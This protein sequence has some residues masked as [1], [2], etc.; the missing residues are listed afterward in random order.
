MTDPDALTV[1]T[2]AIGPFRQRWQESGD[3]PRVLLLHGIYAGASSYEWRRLAPLLVDAGR[4]VRTPDLLGFGDSDHP[5]LEFSPD[6]V[7]EAVRTLL[8]D[9]APATVVAS[10]LTGAYA[11]RAV[12]DG[13]PCERLVLITPTGLGGA[14]AQPSGVL[15]RLAYDV[16]RHTPMGD[17]LVRGLS[18]RPSIRWFLDHQTYTTRTA[19]DDEVEQSR[20]M[21]RRR[22][23][24]HS[25]LAFVFNRLALPVDPAHVRQ[26]APTVIWADGQ[27]FTDPADATRWADAG[28]V[29]EHRR[30][31]LPQVEEPESLLDV[32]AP[33]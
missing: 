25:Q 24:K 27:G 21:A 8:A 33:G 12:A 10:S 22:N 31:G 18:S 17:A 4:Q 29:V 30:C 26:V 14:Q 20:R 9:A 2:T 3:G 13:A 19:D 1:G 28:A 5:D 6:V 32:L 16:G 11:L 7:L 23:G 15:G